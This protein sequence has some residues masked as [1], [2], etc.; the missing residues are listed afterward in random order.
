MARSPNTTASGRPFDPTVIE[1]V[2]NK[3]REDR[4]FTTYRIDMCGA[5]IQKM[6]YGMTTTHGWEIDHIKPVAR[7]GTDDLSN[8]QPLHWENNRGRRHF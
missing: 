8:L 6:D 3:A 5:A 1:A 4:G 7:G 2:W